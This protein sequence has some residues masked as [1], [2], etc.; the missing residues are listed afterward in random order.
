MNLTLS[1]QCAVF[2]IHIQKGPADI[3]RQN[4]KRSNKLD[5]YGLSLSLNKE[6]RQLSFLCTTVK[7]DTR[8]YLGF[9]FSLTELKIMGTQFDTPGGCQELDWACCYITC[10]LF[11]FLLA[12]ENIGNGATMPGLS[13]LLSSCSVQQGQNWSLSHK[14]NLLTFVGWNGAVLGESVTDQCLNNGLYRQ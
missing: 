14:S 12:L 13:R 3:K 5:I 6:S 4:W 9:P 2:L 7:M 1:L 11:T 10:S 8:R